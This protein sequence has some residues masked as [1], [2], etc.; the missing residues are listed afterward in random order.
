M[1][2][3][4]QQA[5]IKNVN[6]AI[7]DIFANRPAAQ[8]TYYIFYSTDTQEI[9]YD[10]GAWVLLGSGGGGGVNIYNS[11]GTLTG[12]RIL[13]GSNN[14]LFFVNLNEFQTKIGNDPQGLRLSFISNNH[15]FGDL[16]NQVGVYVN[17]NSARINIGDTGGNIS[18]TSLEIDA[19][20]EIIQS[21]NQGNNIGLKLDFANQL[22]TLGDPGSFAGALAFIIDN[23]NGVITTQSNPGVNGLYFDL[24]NDYYRLGAFSNVNPTFFEVDNANQIIKTSNQGNDIGLKLDFATNNYYFGN[25]TDNYL[26]VDVING[27]TSIFATN[28]IFNV[29]NDLTNEGSFQI[30]TTLIKSVFNGNDIG[31]KLDFANSVYQFGQIT[32]GNTSNLII[33]DSIETIYTRNQGSDIGIFFD[34]ANTLYKLGQLTG[35][36]ETFIY[37]NDTSELLYTAN[38]GNISNGLYCDFAAHVYQFGRATGGNTTYITID[39][40]ATYPLQID[41][42]NVLSGTSGGSSGQHLKININGTDYKIKLENP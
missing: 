30:Q 14:D 11:D 24:T 15:E 39:D 7:A 27:D 8:S 34:F 1:L 26:R 36:N 4:N 17:G 12:N 3:F 42:T 21:I 41:G 33:D 37:I 22:Y 20:N 23:L 6:G 29:A 10:N 18:Q 32:G 35:G 16:I 31:L 13:S 5:N 9:F 2:V 38:N 40:A 28:G 25:L 19:Q